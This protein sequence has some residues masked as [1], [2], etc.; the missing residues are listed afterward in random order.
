MRRSSE[1]IQG[2]NMHRSQMSELEQL[3]RPP[4]LRTIVC[5]LRNWKQI[6]EILRKAKRETPDGMFISEGLS[7]ETWLSVKLK[8]QLIFLQFTSA[9]FQSVFKG[10]YSRTSA[11]Q[12]V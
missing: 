5:R 6:E 11:K 12:R 3:E 8:W 2:N 9:S 10:S 4:R 7:P 1:R